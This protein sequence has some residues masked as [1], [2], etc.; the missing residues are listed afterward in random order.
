MAAL[1]VTLWEI[2]QLTWTLSMKTERNNIKCNN[3]LYAI[4]YYAEHKE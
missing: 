4:F 1:E 3:V 2:A